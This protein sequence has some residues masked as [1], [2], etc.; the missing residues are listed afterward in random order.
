MTSRLG[1]SKALLHEA[2]G[3]DKASCLTPFLSQEPDIQKQKTRSIYL[4]EIEGVLEL[5]SL[6]TLNILLGGHTTN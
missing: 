5:K 4:L 2:K 1:E 6:Y 3:A